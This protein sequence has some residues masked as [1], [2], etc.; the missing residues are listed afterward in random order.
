MKRILL[1]HSFVLADALNAIRNISMS[2]L[3]CDNTLIEQIQINAFNLVSD[4]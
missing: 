1:N 4:V 3:L 2:R